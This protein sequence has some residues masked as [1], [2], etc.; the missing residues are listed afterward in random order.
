M[1]DKLLSEVTDMSFEVTHCWVEIL[2]ARITQASLHSIMLRAVILL[3][4]SCIYRKL[5][6]F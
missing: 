1:R 5:T 3:F 2:S 6:S 4:L